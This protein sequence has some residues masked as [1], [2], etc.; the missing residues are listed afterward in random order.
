MSTTFR[1][2]S[3]EETI[4]RARALG[5]R[6]LPTG[7]ILLF[8]NLGT[9][10]TVFVRGL[11]EAAGGRSDEVTSP[12]FTLIQEYTGVQSVHH[13]DLY[14]IKRDEIEELGL[15][16]LMAGPGLVAIEWAEKL[17]RPPTNAFQVYIEDKGQNSRE[18][19]IE[20][21]NTFGGSCI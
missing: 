2:R 21:N 14:R 20:N 9:G 19:R 13:V 17:P 12:T 10:K 6:V 18:F 11:V 4:K 15:D 1:T 7:V 3:E 8:G 16:E 5:D